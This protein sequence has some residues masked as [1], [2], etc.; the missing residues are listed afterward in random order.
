M[1][2]SQRTGICVGGVLDGET[3]TDGQSFGIG[4]DPQRPDEF[5]FDMYEWTEAKD[6]NGNVRGFYRHDH[7]SVEEATARLFS[8]NGT[9]K[10]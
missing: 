2:G 6:A 7:L 4:R 5:P 8:E 3:R 9:A 1:T 10:Q